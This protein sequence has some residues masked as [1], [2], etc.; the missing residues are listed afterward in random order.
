MSGD[1]SGPIEVR[2]ARMGDLTALVALENRVFP[3]DRL[4]RANF[5]HAIRSPTITCLVAARGEDLLGYVTVMRR[6]GSRLAHL[7]SIAATEGGRGV[8]RLLLKAA[9]AVAGGEGCDRMRLEVRADNAT[10]LRLYDR[11]GYHRF[12]TEEA[13]YED[14]SAA[15]RYEKALTAGEPSSR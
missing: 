14:G 15:H 10:A 2:P 8:G 13:Y 3:T 12:A 11:A 5:R 9:E 6:K 1:A 4:D 7:A